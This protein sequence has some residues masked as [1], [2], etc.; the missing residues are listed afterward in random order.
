MW[1]YKIDQQE[2]HFIQFDEN[3][4]VATVKE[5]LIFKCPSLQKLSL[6]R[7][8]SEK[9]LERRESVVTHDLTHDTEF[10]CH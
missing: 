6:A 5:K 1:W 4:I 8:P 2:A 7:S 3:D 10:R 9:C